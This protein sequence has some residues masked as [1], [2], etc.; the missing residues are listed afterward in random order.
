[1]FVKAGS[2]FSA[3]SRRSK[4]SPVVNALLVRQAFS[5]VL[6]KVCKDLPK[7]ALDSVKAVSFK[8]GVLVVKVQGLARAE[9]L[10]RS[11]GLIKGVNEALGKR[12]VVKLRF[13]N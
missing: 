2:L 10:M 12:V 1:M 8:E 11:G 9:L 3:L 13:K 7:E 4:I 5:E 6:P